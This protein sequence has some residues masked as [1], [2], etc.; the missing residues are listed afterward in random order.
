MFRLKKEAQKTKEFLSAANTGEMEVQALTPDHDF[1]T[2]ISRKLFEELSKDIIEKAE[3][4]LDNLFKS[5]DFK[6]SMIDDV[7]IIGGA[8][9]IPVMQ[10]MLVDFF[11]GKVLN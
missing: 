10:K 2:S 9:R 6:K 3:D 5:S 8:S 4:V 7:I 11:D 1:E